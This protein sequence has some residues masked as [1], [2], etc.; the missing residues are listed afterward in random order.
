MQMGHGCGVANATVCN[1]GRMAKDL[2]KQICNRIRELR[3]KQDLTQQ[4]LAEKAGLDYKSIQRLEAKAPRFYPK[5]HT[6][7]KV[8]EAFR[9]NL[10][11]FF[12]GIR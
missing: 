6:L 8:A 12:K 1:T 10:S 11:D 5:I 3:A 2:R 4:E 7:A 9:L